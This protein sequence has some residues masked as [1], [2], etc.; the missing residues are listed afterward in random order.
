MLAHIV[1]NDFWLVRQAYRREVQIL[2]IAAHD[3]R[4]RAQRLDAIDTVSQ[5]K[6]VPVAAG[7]AHRIQMRLLTS[8]WRAPAVACAVQQVITDES[9]LESIAGRLWQ[10]LITRCRRC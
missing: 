4:V 9:I 2:A 5:R 10:L 8:L 3:D 7:P 6:I 1:V